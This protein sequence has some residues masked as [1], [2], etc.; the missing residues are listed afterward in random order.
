M[1]NLNKGFTLVEMLVVVAIIGILSAS[2][3]VA[4]G[5]A[6]EKAKDARIISAVGQV[7]SLMEVY[8]NPSK[9]AY[10]I[11][12]LITKAEYTAA[13][14]E[15]NNNQT[16]SNVI[17]KKLQINPIT[18]FSSTFSVSAQLNS[19]K[20]WCADSTGFSGQRNSVGVIACPAE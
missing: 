8:F 3:L 12:T 20:W 19:G 1:K 6:R 18:G 5:P 17:T 14:N 9:G 16:G 4:L 15:V 2:V 10:D 13:D 7:R 11:T